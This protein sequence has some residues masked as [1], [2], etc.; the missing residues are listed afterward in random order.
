M[1]K[2]VLVRPGA[3]LTSGETRRWERDGGDARW[4]AEK[5]ETG[6]E[7]ERGEERD[8]LTVLSARS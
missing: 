6:K 3:Y 5:D 2:R 8:L 4:R 1:E 7:R